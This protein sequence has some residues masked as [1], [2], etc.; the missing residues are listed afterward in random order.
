MVDEL[1]IWPRCMCSSSFTEHWIKKVVYWAGNYSC[2][3][4]I[5]STLLCQLSTDKL[6]EMKNYFFFF[7]KKKNYYF[8]QRSLL[9][10]D[11]SNCCSND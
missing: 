9:K 8:M 4:V 6:Y 10:V 1:Y 2:N 11:A 3:R 5:I 7:F